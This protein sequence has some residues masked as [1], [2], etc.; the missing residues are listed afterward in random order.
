MN[1]TEKKLSQEILNLTEK[2]LKHF[3]R[4]LSIT[5]KVFNEELKYKNISME[6]IKNAVIF[7]KSQNQE[8]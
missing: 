7:A 2:Q 1:N 5:V 3:T 4:A 6:D 8:Y